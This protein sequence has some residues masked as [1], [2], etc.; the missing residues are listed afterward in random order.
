MATTRSTQ[1]QTGR[2]VQGGDSDSTTGKLGWW[3][4]RIF[5]RSTSDVQFKISTK[6]HRRPDLLAFDVYGRATLMWVILQYNNIV[7]INEEF[8]EG[9]TI[10]LPTQVRLQTEILAKT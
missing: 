9:K 5:P 1:I 4:R 2:Y 8:L 3:E 6:Y 10:T 7:D